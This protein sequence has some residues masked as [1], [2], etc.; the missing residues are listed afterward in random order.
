M[1]TKPQLEI[2]TDDVKCSHGTTIGQLDEEALFYMRSRGIGIDV[3]RT[4]LMQA[5]MSDVIDA[6]RMDLLRDRLRHLVEK[7]FNGSLASCANCVSS[8]KTPN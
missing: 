8:C 4:M 3:A 1:Y 5:F 7:R 2:Y 6:V